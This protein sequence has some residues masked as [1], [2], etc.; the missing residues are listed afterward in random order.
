VK[1]ETDTELLG[2]VIKHVPNPTFAPKPR[3]YCVAELLA[4]G[5]GSAMDMCRRFGHDPDQTIDGVAC[6]HCDEEGEDDGDQ[7]EARER[8]QGVEQ[9]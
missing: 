1:P 3:W 5:S 6:Q 4:I 2:R 7:E 9:Q 8:D